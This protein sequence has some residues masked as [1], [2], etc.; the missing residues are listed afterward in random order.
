MC[1]ESAENS[2]RRIHVFDMD[3]TLLRNTTA[4]ALIAEALGA[5]RQF[6][7]L[8]EDL[9]N[10]ILTTVGFAEQAFELWRTLESSAIT[11]AFTRGRHIRGI[12]D[13]LFDIRQRG[14]YSMLI[15]MSPEFFAREYLPSGFDE[16][17]GSKFPPLPFQ[18]TRFDPSGILTPDDKPK[19]VRERCVQF[20]TTMQNVVAYGDS[21]SD[22]PLF[23]EVGLAVAINADSAARRAAH[24]KYEGENLGEA[25]EIALRALANSKYFDRTA[26]SDKPPLSDNQ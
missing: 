18:Q 24:L 21:K 3:G 10:G 13:V 8:E 1:A 20:G 16:V 11:A 26:T 22:L 23:G 6:A 19:I 17:V 7:Q 5:E 4:S 9:R 14:D 2:P 25:Y 15:T 12:H